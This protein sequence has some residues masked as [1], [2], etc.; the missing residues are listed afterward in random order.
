MKVIEYQDKYKQDFIRLNLNWIE[1]YFSLEEEDRR[2][3]DH[4]EEE[5]ASG[6]M[7]YLALIDENVAAVCMAVPTGDNVWEICKLA[8]DDR[9]KGHGAGSAVFK[10]CMD[11]AVAHGAEKLTLISNSILT[12]ALHI[13]RKFGFR[14]VEVDRTEYARCD[15][16]FEYM[17]NKK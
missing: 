14:Q 6:G 7:I 15:I 4:I 3:L 10:A 12:P 8:A 9:W 1:N 13:Y 16:Q 5:I 11:Y 2:I 17:V